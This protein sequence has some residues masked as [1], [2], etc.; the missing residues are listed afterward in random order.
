MRCQP[1]S[2]ELIYIK[3]QPGKTKEALQHLEKVYN[4]FSELPFTYH[5]LDQTLEQ[6]YKREMAIQKLAGYFS[7]LAIIISCLGLLGLASYSA[8]RRTK[9]MAI[10]KVMGAKIANIIH[11]LLS[12]YFQLILIG[13]FIGLPVAYYWTNNWLNSFAYRVQL[14]WWIYAI[15][16]AFIFFIAFLTVSKLSFKTAQTNPVDSLRND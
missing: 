12:E 11:L 14:D 10:R 16:G 5:F 9:E 7:I 2:T 1:S 8:E 13:L 3:T 6:G 15:P 4:S